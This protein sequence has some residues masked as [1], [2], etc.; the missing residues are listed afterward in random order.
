MGTTETPENRARTAEAAGA[1]ADAARRPEPDEPFLVGADADHEHMFRSSWGLLPTQWRPVGSMAL[2]THQAS[3]VY[4][5]HAAGS[6]SLLKAR[7]A[8][9]LIASTETP[10]RAEPTGRG[11]ELTVP[12]GLA[13]R[14]LRLL[15]ANR[16][17][18]DA[19]I[20]P[21]PKT[22]G[23]ARLVDQLRGRARSY[24]AG[25]EVVVGP[26]AAGVMAGRLALQR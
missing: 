1:E 3:L 10:L 19:L 21:Q 24:D 13:G 11:L 17:L 6:P 14:H 4:R 9:D 2:V 12:I 22:P 5:P 15:E 26:A 20:L 18:P 25:I 8:Y 7:K 16:C 23:V